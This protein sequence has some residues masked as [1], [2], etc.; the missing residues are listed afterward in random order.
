MSDS[1]NDEHIHLVQAMM[2][3][4]DVL[5][6]AIELHRAT[7]GDHNWAKRMDA[8]CNNV[9]RDLSLDSPLRPV[10]HE[11]HRLSLATL[12]AQDPVLSACVDEIEKILGDIIGTLNSEA[13]VLDRPV[14]LDR[15]ESQRLD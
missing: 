10:V 11:Q 8:E 13:F 2:R 4:K 7:Y 5:Q 14:D 12:D 3:A 15:V 1:Q 6:A 9:I